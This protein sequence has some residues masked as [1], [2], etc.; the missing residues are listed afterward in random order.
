V[1][2]TR[3]LPGA[4]LRARTKFGLPPAGKARWYQL[5]VEDTAG[6]RAYTDP[7][8]AGDARVQQ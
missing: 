3:V 5:L 1:I 8:W 2:E 4:P 7:I 6:R